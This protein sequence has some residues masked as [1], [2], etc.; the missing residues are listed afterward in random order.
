MND[1]FFIHQITVYHTEDDENFTI[2]HYDGKDLPKVYFRH[3]KKIN[4]IDKGLQK[5]STGSITIP[6]TEELNISTDDYIVEGIID[7]KFD[8]S[9]LQQKYQVFKV[10]SVDDNRKGNLQHYKIG[11]SE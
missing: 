6:T 5:G 4:V 8:L 9:A 10:V 2:Q 11:V 1:R 3:N 7:D